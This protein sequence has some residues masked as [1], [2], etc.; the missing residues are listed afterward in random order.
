M[1]KR[2]PPTPT[3]FGIWLRMN[4]LNRDWSI[5]HLA[6]VSQ[7]QPI[8]IRKL[9]SGE[10]RS[11]DQQTRTNLVATIN[12]Q[13]IKRRSNRSK[14]PSLHPGPVGA[15]IYQNRAA[16]NWSQE[17]LALLSNMDVDIIDDIETGA[18]PELSFQ[19]RRAIE[20][21]FQEHIGYASAK[22]QRESPQLQDRRTTTSP[23]PITPT[24]PSTAGGHAPLRIEDL[25]DLN[26]TEFEDLTV[27]LFQ[28][29][30][31]TEVKRTGGAGDL[32]A[33]LTARDQNGRYTIVQCK[34]FA[35]GSQVG[36][37]VVQTFIGMK[38]VHH[39]AERGAIVTTATFSQPAA[40]LAR[41]HDIDF[42]DGD[43]CLR[44][45][46]LTGVR[47]P[48]HIRQAMDAGRTPQTVGASQDLS[49]APQVA[50][51]ATSDEFRE[52]MRS[53]RTLRNLT[54]EAVA[55]MSGLTPALV[56]AIETGDVRNPKTDLRIQ[57]AVALCSVT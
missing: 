1:F 29:L 35:P 34:R 32:N 39:R 23:P 22:E 25:L 47:H 52:W 9:E 3:E 8:V 11:P 13:P 48:R 16:K 37:P 31:Y 17:H 19:Q 5:E 56:I 2:R 40:T 24:G 6:Y 18:I 10:M 4:R 14:R 51:T 38:N 12:G 43:D 53:T 15:L 28:A 50:I 36:S 42:I 26:P 57:I 45:L 33:D 27:L 7:V 21:A 55:H 46:A 20:K 41:Q 49:S 44:L 54:H 30:G